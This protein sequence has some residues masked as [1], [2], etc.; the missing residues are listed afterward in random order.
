MDAVCFALKLGHPQRVELLDVGDTS[1]D[2]FPRWSTVRY[3]FPQRGELP[4]IAVFWYEGSKPNT[5]ATAPGSEGKPARPRPNLPPVF[6]EI[7]RHDKDLAK[8][9]SG[10]GNVFVGEKGMICCLSHGGF[11]VLLPAERRQEFAP[12]PK[13]QPRPSGGI[14]GDFLRACQAGGGP[15][16][17]GFATFA[18]PFLE[19]LL[20]GHLAMRAGLNKPVEW[21]GVNM[22]CTNLPNLNQYVRREYRKGW[23]L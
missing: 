3:D 1:E 11:P 16:C 17:S 8:K 6:A 13:S 22:K 9:M 5:D 19:M 7:Q 14:M 12:P 2:R 10:A 18:G 20:V 21:D 4:P 23:T 15:T